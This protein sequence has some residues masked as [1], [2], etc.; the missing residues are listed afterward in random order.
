MKKVRL[1]I[2]SIFYLM[3]SIIIALAVTSC[4]SENDGKKDNSDRMPVPKKLIDKF[5][6]M[7]GVSMGKNF[8]RDSLYD[9]NY[10]YLIA[11]IKDVLAKKELLLTGVELDSVNSQMQRLLADR[12]KRQLLSDRKSAEDT[13]KEAYEFLSQNKSSQGVKTLSSGLQYK[14]LKEG[15]GSSPKIGDFVK[16]HA[17]ATVLNGKEIE[18]SFKK[19]KPIKVQLKDGLLLA[20]LQAIP[21]MKKGSRWIIYSPPEFAF[22]E[23]G[24]KD[25]PINK[26][27]LFEIELLD[28]QIEPYPDMPPEPKGL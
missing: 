12:Q 14:I 26:V 17:K 1:S 10:D 8:E 21:L 18:D 6:Y 20:W 16:I 22:G 15:S 19:N 5:S 3:L 4:Q 25:V 27:M 23:R 7:V 13:K 28:F 11:A 24:S 2:Q 9:V